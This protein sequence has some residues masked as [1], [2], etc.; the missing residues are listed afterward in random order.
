[1][2]FSHPFQTVNISIVL[3]GG[4]GDM[5]N[6]NIG[7]QYGNVYYGCIRGDYITISSFVYRSGYKAGWYA[8]GY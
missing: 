1:M 5:S 4:H 2:S 8:C 3:T 7:V 6:N